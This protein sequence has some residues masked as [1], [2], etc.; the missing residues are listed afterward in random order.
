MAQMKL[1]VPSQD[2]LEDRLINFVALSRRW[3]CHPKIAWRR[4]QQLGIPVIR[5]NSRSHAVRLSDVLKAEISL[6]TS[7]LEPPMT[8]CVAVY[9]KKR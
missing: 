5:F 8:C 4:V 3:N 9:Q 6:E 2:P 7:K 1:F